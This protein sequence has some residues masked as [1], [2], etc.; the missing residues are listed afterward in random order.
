MVLKSLFLILTLFLVSCSSGK[1]KE[2]E[3][4]EE[5]QVIEPKSL[6]LV[7]CESCHGLD[8]KKGTS[9]AADLSKSKINDQ[10][11]LYVIENGN[12]KGMMPYKNLITSKEERLS[13]VEFV[14]TLRK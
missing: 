6:Y 14:K 7:H 12:N 3:F 13:L 9:G 11:I 5:E 1:A 4:E 2:Y 8:G 10:E